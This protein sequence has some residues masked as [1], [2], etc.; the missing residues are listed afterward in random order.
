VQ[1]CNDNPNKVI[2]T[3]EEMTKNYPGKEVDMSVS[4]DR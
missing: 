4:S 1:E 2:R 3:R